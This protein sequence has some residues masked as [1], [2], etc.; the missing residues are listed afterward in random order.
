MTASSVIRA[1]LGLVVFAL[2]LVHTG[3][4]WPMRL[5]DTVE[6]LTYDMR[7]RLSLSGE[8]DPRVVI[9]DI[10]EKSIAAEGRWPWPRDKLAQLL[11]QLFNRYQVRVAGFDTN[12]PEGDRAGLALLDHLA[13]ALSDLEG[14]PQRLQDIRPRFDTDARFAQ[15]IAS[16]PVVLGMVF[17][18]PSTLEPDEV[19]NAHVGEIC[20][21]A[22]GPAQARHY[23]VDLPKPSGYVGNLAS[24]QGAAPLCGF[25]ENPLVDGDGVFRRVPLLQRYADG[26]YPSLAVALTR[27]ALGNPPITLEFEPP[28]AQV[29]LNLE[30]LRIGERSVPVDGE[31]AA[32]VPFRGGYRT[33]R[34]VPATDVLSGR[35]DPALLRDTVVIV[36]TSAAGLLDLRTT[37]VGR[38]FVGVEI[39]A[40]L[41]SGMLDGLIKHKAPYY[42]GIETLMMLG[43]ALL[44]ILLLPWISPLAAAGL[45]AGLI[46]GIV[47]LGL[48]AWNTANFIMP[49]GVVML[50]T[51]TVFV[52]LMLY[53]YFVEER[54][55]RQMARLFGHYVPPE[56]VAEL[57][58]HPEAMSMAGERRQMSVLF[59]DIRGFTSIAERMDARE[60]A[61]LMNEYLSRQT[62]VV[63]RHRG[64][65][66]K[67]IG[68]AIMA[69]WGAPLPDAAH[70]ENALRAAM[71]MVQAV[72][73]L[74]AGF[75]A[76]GWPSLKIGVGVSSGPMHVGNMGSDFRMSYTVMGDVVNLGS[77]LQDLTKVYGVAVIC[78]DVTRTLVP[79]WAF[80]ELDRVR[81]KGRQE[82]LAIYEPLGP[83]DALST[84]VRQDL[85]RYRTALKH[86]R[87]REW[88]AAEAEFFG[89]SRS[90]RPHPV[91]ELFLSRIAQLRKQPPAAD[92]SA[93]FNQLT[94]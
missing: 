44:M 86:Y 27:A 31:G 38:G 14:V 66:D 56:L 81:V 54:G 77:R 13:P 32:Y 89:L 1:G 39:H 75:V 88:D 29:S 64:T 84:E 79:A 49:M 45:A 58:L 92:W 2:F 51:V 65:I 12:F 70:A 80:R 7:V 43:V 55:K 69:F 8:G 16:R 78:A 73:E 72:R 20:A 57:A 9:V 63:Q 46:A 71:E 10:D 60:L 19:A 50:F 68:D 40:N 33:M 42:S 18:A 76:K 5:L 35:A 4:W 94:K 67:Y 87:A 11:D 22:I 21:P 3:G 25:F 90:S 52:V 93:T 23:A 30:R 83:K 85:V 47:A 24:L 41:V 26:L 34:Y 61:A 53:G 17:S 37:P 15:A 48:V 28:D 6:N 59:C 82:A 74:D 36:G 91:Y 62:V